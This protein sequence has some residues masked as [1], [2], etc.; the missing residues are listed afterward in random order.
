MKFLGPYKGDV[1]FDV[2]YRNNS[3][4]FLFTKCAN[5]ARVLLDQ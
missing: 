2:K 5:V 1:E 4:V 3:I